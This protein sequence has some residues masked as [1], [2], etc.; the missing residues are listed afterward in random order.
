MLIGNQTGFWQPGM[1]ARHQATL[2]PLIFIR[3]EESFG[4]NAAPRQNAGNI[5]V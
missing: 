3:I 5:T 2:P 1:N 4:A